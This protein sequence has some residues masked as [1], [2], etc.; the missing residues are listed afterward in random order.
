MRIIRCSGSE[1]RDLMTTNSTVIQLEMIKNCNIVI[2]RETR[3]GWPLLTVETYVIWDSMSTNETGPS[4][5][6]SS[7]LSCRY[8]IFLFC[9]GCFSWPS[10]KYFFLAVHYFN[11]SVPIAQQAGQPAVLGRLSLS[12]CLWLSLG[13][14][15][16]RPNYRRSLQ[17]S[18]RTYSTSK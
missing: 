9:L 6:G 2:P 18:K 3:D 17:P 12:M 8:K 15:E 11:S 7:G 10:T 4:M 5:V 16:R 13:L 14:H 1:S